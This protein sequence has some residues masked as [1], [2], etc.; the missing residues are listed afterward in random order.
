VP[1]QLE[2]AH[3]ALSLDGLL[4]LELINTEMMERGKRHDVLTSPDKLARW[5]AEVC[6]LYPEQCAVEGALAP[7]AWTSEMLDA[8]KALRMALRRLITRVVE[9]HAVEE[10]NLQLLN[11]VLAL[12]YS[13]LERTGQGHVK[14]VMHLRDP[15][16]GRLL[17]P[18]AVS[19]L[20]LFTETD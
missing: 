9:Q 11:E 2:L 10:E 12:G 19:A 5:W 8:V 14:T 20:R 4:A 3:A 17:F 7:T 13:A 6:E 16:Q 1:G 18:I 15:Q